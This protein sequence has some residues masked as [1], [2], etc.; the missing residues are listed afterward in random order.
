MNKKVNIFIIL[1]FF[2]ASSSTVLSNVIPANTVWSGEITVEEDILVPEGITLTILPGTKVNI[3]PSDS[4]RS[5][6]EYLSSLTE[7]T[8]RGKLEARGS[9]DAPISFHIEGAKESDSWAGLIIDG[10][11]VHLM[12]C[13][14]R[15]AE[16]GIRIIE[17]RL[18]LEDSVLSRN[19]YGLIAQG[20]K[21][22]LYIKNTAIKEN[23]FG[24]FLLNGAQIADGNN[25]I[26]DNKKKDMYSP[27]LLKNYAPSLKDYKAEEKD[28]SGRYGDE[29]LQG[30]TVWRGSIEVSGLVRIPEGARLVIMPGAV[31]EFTKKDSNNDGIGE[32]G[33]MIQGVIISKGTREKPIIFRSA[34]RSKKMGDW[35]SINI[36]LL[37]GFVWIHI[38]LPAEE[39]YCNS[40]VLKIPESSCC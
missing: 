30:D 27:P 29:V 26:R 4:T 22:V 31:I 18:E 10:G 2:V 7:I 25:F 15:N 14:I 5:N 1:L 17:G 13:S 36:L 20:K 23:I 19:Q 8:I 32:N 40:K 6:P 3:M 9:K 11:S 38:Q 33:L 35:D 21:V 39:Q 28:I 37:L 34:E 24:V 12:S 16:S